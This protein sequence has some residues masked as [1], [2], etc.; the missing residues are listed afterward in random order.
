MNFKWED[1]IFSFKEDTE[2]TVGDTTK[3]YKKGE[4][5]PVRFINGRNVFIMYDLGIW[6]SFPVTLFNFT[7]EGNAFYG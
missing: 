4:E 2:V 5:L 7:F 6:A 3:I 1:A